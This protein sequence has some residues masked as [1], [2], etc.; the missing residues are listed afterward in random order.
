MTLGS[1]E[2]SF[3]DLPAEL[4][5]FPLPGALLLPH[6]QLPLNIF[7][8]RYLEMISAAL[9]G[10]R[11]IGMIQPAADVDQAGP[12]ADEVPIF[13][14]GCAGRIV[15]FQEADDHRLLITLKGICRF[16]VTEELPVYQGFR[17]VRPDYA[18]YAADLGPEVDADIDR[19]RLLGDLRAYFDESGIAADWDAIE[20]APT[21]RLVTTLAMVC[22]FETDEKQA[23]LESPDTARRAKLMIALIEAALR[24]DDL[25]TRTARH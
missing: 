20:R 6:G 25:T 11:M 3:A 14:V 21:A 12:V 18:P 23:L 4:P 17:R 16:A 15:A 9:A 1:F 19:L 2:P 13:S 7:E 8:P 22:P 5:I 10:P 24:S